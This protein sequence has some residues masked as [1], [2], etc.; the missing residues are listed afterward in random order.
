[1][2]EY[3]F[4]VADDSFVLWSIKMLLSALFTPV[5]ILL[6]ALGVSFDLN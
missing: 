2:K 6:Q 1:M 5:F 3:Y 4:Y